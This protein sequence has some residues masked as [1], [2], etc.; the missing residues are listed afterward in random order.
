VKFVFVFCPLVGWNPFDVM[1]LMELFYKY[2][3]HMYS[4]LWYPIIFFK[5]NCQ[6]ITYTSPFY[7]DDN[8]IINIVMRD[9]LL[10]Y[11][12]VGHE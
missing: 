5:N 7:I 3:N 8:D 2:F 10:S 6:E 9:Y 11:F 12:R 1:L 4:L